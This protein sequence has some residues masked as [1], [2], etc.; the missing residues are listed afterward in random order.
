MIVISSQPLCV[1]VFGWK[2][3][4]RSYVF[5]AEGWSFCFPLLFRQFKSYVRAEPAFFAGADGVGVVCIEEMGEDFMPM[6]WP[7]ALVAGRPFSSNATLPSKR[8][9]MRIFSMSSWRT[10]MTVRG[11][12]A[13]R[14]FLTGMNGIFDEVGKDHG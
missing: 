4:A 6:P 11:A 13:L 8:F 12:L 7:G 5:S 10:A 9:L 2:R 3:D 1:G 14:L